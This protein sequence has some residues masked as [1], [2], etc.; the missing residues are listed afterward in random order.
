EAL[1]RQGVKREFKERVLRHMIQAMF[2]EG[3]SDKAAE[4]VERLLKDHGDDWQN[5][6][7]KAWIENERGHA[8]EAFKIYKDVLD[9][10]RR[11]TSLSEADRSDEQTTVTASIL[12]VIDRLAVEKKYE[13]SQRMSQDLLDTLEKIGASSDLKDGA[14]RQL[15][16]SMI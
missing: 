15:I 12:G 11:D 6:K 16:Q 14:A 10:I 5:L 2:K 8:N 3:K 4:M 1:E 9:R 13:Q 7:L